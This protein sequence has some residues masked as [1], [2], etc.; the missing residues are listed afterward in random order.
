[1]FSKKNDI[2]K[3]SKMKYI[4]GILAG[5]IL[6]FCEMVAFCQETNSNIDKSI[7]DLENQ[8]ATFEQSKNTLELAR[9][10]TKLGFLYK[11]KNV[12]SKAIEYFQKAIKSNEDLG[13]LNAIK[14]LCINLGMLYNEIEDYNQALLYLE[15]SLRI[16]EKQDKKRDML[17]DL[18]NIAFIHQNQKNYTESNKILEK[19]TAIGQELSNIASL[20][21][22]YS[23]LSENYNILG[24]PEKAKEYFDLASTINSHLQKEEIKKF[25]S[26]TIQA[27]AT[28]NA[29]DVEI[30]SK[31]IEIQKMSREQQLTL[32]LLKKEKEL[33]EFKERESLA[34]RRYT[35]L[36]IISLTS[37]L[38]IVCSSM[39]FIF[40]QLR[41]K[42]K[43]YTMLEHSNQ[44]VVEQKKEI[45]EQRDLANI[46][47]KKITDSIF[48]AK[49]I[50][51]AILPPMSYI[52]KV[53]PEHFILF[54]PR[55][56]VSGDFYWMTEKD[57]I[58]II[59]AADCTGHGVPGA[60]MS[61]LGIAYL[62]EIVN[63]ITVNRHI[64]SLHANEI[65]NQLRENV[66]KSLHQTGKIEETKDGMDI[67]LCII[68]YEN[69][70]MQFAGAHNPVYIIR[71]D[72]LE[73]IDAD[74]MPI[75]IYKQSDKL[76]T[77]YETTLEKNDLVYMFSDGYYDQF[78]SKQKTKIF[79][80]NFRKVILEN[81]KKPMLEQKKILEEF[82]DNWKGDADQVDD[83]LVIGF[84]FDPH[85][86]ATPIRP[87]FLW[88]EKKILIAEDLD[89]NYILL[90]EA[91]K[92]TKA[93]ITRV[94][95]GL[96]AVE[97]C[98][99][100]E[101]DL[102]LMDIRMPVMDGIEAT[103]Q[104]RKFNRELPII[105][106]TANSEPDD[107]RTI[108][109]AGC[110]EYISK[111]INLNIFLDVLRKHLDT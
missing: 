62:N 52:D 108:H 33:N 37:I 9:C 18:I 97:Y 21:S 80:A 28:S 51:N 87:Q 45:E 70:S 71:N 2:Y 53:L 30:K 101:A 43:A 14:N 57:G 39:F 34:I 31:N 48:Y 1:M 91:L 104:I 74:K 46:Q 77:N 49:R 60:F 3:N 40:K 58:L 110:N 11:D 35:N 106:Q 76:F 92:P 107:I 99:N 85:F 88:H 75:G 38:V 83:V 54:R 68:D 56:I 27:E 17:S 36:I 4:K 22:C 10:Q 109:E 61:M 5:L 78:G 63:K 81:H 102:I 20:K 64:R 41:E 50:Q 86:R 15:K 69:R 16:N 44:Q 89:L 65:L 6:L 29:K 79:S 42:K 105:A 90:V 72:N 96:E 24:N 94:M 95:N 66:I 98:K 47:K 23:M 26:R 67:S 103:K 8:V 111:P 12:N 93:K 73:Q 19:A 7:S 100:N 13:N 32:D 59:V 55:D 82:Y 25:E 84:K